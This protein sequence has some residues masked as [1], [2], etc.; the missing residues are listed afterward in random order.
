MWT[1]FV[2]AI[3]VL[4]LIF[5]PILVAFAIV[6]SIIAALRAVTAGS[7]TASTKQRVRFSVV[8]AVP[9][10]EH[11]VSARLEAKI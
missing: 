1:G 3:F 4:F 10:G 6:G 7:H 11:R 9:S 2:E 5:L 8:A